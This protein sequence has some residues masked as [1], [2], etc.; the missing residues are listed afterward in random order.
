M[1]DELFPAILTMREMRKE[2]WRRDGEGGKLALER[3]R[4]R[5]RSLR[6]GRRRR[7]GKSLLAANRK[8][9]IFD[10]VLLQEDI[11]SWRLVIYLPRRLGDGK[12]SSVKVKVKCLIKQE[13]ESNFQ[14]YYF[15]LHRGRD[16]D[17][18]S[19]LWSR[20]KLLIWFIVRALTVGFQEYPINMGS[21]KWNLQRGRY[22]K[23]ID[24]WRQQRLVFITRRNFYLNILMSKQSSAVCNWD[25]Q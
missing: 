19:F 13:S 23:I 20:R 5:K 22:F 8:S 17:G 9:D 21:P 11:W 15:P 2:T 24:V 3:S 14:N 4:E 16:H 12:R 6:K 18:W 1:S 25:I 7:R 10:G